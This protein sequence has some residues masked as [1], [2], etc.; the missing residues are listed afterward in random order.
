LRP[1]A[2]A[3]AS[4]GSALVLERRVL[5]LTEVGVL[6]E[7]DLPVERDDPPVT[8]LHEWVDLHKGGVLGDEDIPELDD[9]RG[10]LVAYV[11]GE[12]ALLRDLAR[13]G[14]VDAGER[15]DGNP[16]QRLGFLHGQLLD[17]HATLAGGHR[18][19]RAVGPVEQHR[20]VVLLL[21]RGCWGQHHAVHRVALDVHAEDRRGDLLGFLDRRRELHAARLAA[22]T[23]LDLRLDHDP[24]TAFWQQPLRSSARLLRR[25]RYRPA[26]DRDAVLLEQIARLIFEQIHCRPRSSHSHRWGSAWRRERNH[27]AAGALNRLNPTGS[28]GPARAARRTPL[29]LLSALATLSGVLVITSPPG[30]AAEAPQA[31]TMPTVTKTSHEIDVHVGPAGAQTRTIVYDLYTPVEIELPGVGHRL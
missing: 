29:V 22:A 16:C 7:G 25:L 15:I 3:L 19:V 4:N 20:E 31:V 2:F 23:G 27:R 12:A 8:G 13:L 5:G 10:H 14:L 6:V 30:A 21:D 17:L 24:A 11:F 26:K 1:F 9:G 28:G 18:E